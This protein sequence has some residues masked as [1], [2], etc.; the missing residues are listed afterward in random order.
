MRADAKA[1]GLT[2]FFTGKPCKHGHISQRGTATGACITCNNAYSLAFH[3]AHPQQAAAQSKAWKAANIDQVRAAGRKYSKEH[4]EQ[5]RAWKAAN[6]DKVNAG[7]R[8]AR[9]ANP[10]KYRAMAARYTSSDEGKAKRKAYYQ[11]NAEKIRRRTSE[12]KR[13]NP[14]RAHKNQTLW[15]L[16]NTEAVKRRARAWD[17]ANPEAARARGRNYRA[18]SRQAEG[19]H[20]AE[21][22]QRIGAAQKWRCH[23]CSKPAKTGYHVDHVQPLSK[24]GTNWPSN[25]VISC[26]P[27]NVSKRASDPLAFA[28][29]LGLLL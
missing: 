19:S 20:T 24:G 25:L 17:E 28:R 9:L 13:Q 3:K 11:A 26:G 29:R 7:E 4:R 1:A 12:W 5:G 2:R 15:Y 22:I 18:R 16:I 27:C 23:W 8:Q 6:R 10:D 14:D 21:D